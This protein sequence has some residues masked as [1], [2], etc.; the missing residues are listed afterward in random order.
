MAELA[1]MEFPPLPRAS[2]FIPTAEQTPTAASVTMWDGR[3]VALEAALAIMA[4]LDSP[5][6]RIVARFGDWVVT[7]FG[8]ECLSHVYFIEADRLNEDW[9]NH[10]CEKVWVHM[11][12]FLAAFR[13]AKEY[14]AVSADD[15]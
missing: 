9:P 4:A 15:C 5:L 8:V 1:T 11:P 3:V 14:H 7:Q 12:D 2:D 6:D 10:M 13:F